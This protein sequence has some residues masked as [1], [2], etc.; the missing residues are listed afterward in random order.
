MTFKWRKSKEK[1]DSM[2]IAKKFKEQIRLSPYSL[3]QV[4]VL[5]RAAIRGGEVVLKKVGNRFSLNSSS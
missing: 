3:S 2:R 4:S 1:E 5:V